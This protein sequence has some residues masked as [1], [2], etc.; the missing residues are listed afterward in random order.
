MQALLKVLIG[1]M[2]QPNPLRKPHVLM[3]SCLRNYLETLNGNYRLRLR[4]V[5][6]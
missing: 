6:I 2:A 1:R 4:K 3:V 5:M